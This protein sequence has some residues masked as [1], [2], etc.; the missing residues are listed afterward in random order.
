MDTEG[1]FLA[2][3]IERFVS[4]VGIRANTQALNLGV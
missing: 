4:V 3:T 1:S 2:E